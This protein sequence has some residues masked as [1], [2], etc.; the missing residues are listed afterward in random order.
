MSLFGC[1]F[2]IEFSKC[3]ASRK[4]GV[5]VSE[6]NRAQASESWDERDTRKP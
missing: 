5:V 3:F 2:E 4:A 1:L 6:R